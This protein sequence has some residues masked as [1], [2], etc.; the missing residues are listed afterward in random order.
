M[1]GDPCMFTSLDEEVDGQER[2]LICSPRMAHFSATFALAGS[3][4]MTRFG[5]LEFPALPPV[6]MRIPPVFESSQ[7]FL[8]GRL[9]FVVDRLGVLHLREET[10]VPAPVG[11]APS[12]GS[13][14][15]DDFNDEASTLHSEQTLC[16]NPAMSNMHTV[17]YSLFTI[18]HQSSRGTVSPMTQTS[19]DRFPYGVASSTDAYAR[20]LRRM[21]APSPLAS[22]FMGM[23]SYAPATFHELPD[24]EGESDGSSISDV[25]P[26]HRLSRECTM[27]DALGR[28]RGGSGV[29]TDS[30][31]SGP[32]CG[33]PRARTKAR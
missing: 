6:G 31:P 5:S 19:Y 8:F 1:T 28:P 15:H 3:S 10:L 18:S 12:I 21:L 24:D 26:R 23:A 33:G 9:V 20:G 32:S 27:A 22:K 25:A 17:I 11:G 30:H 7:A 13:G 14:T 4:D 16:S 2:I 29:L